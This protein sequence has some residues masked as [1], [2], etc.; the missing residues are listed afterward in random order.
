MPANTAAYVVITPQKHIEVKEAPYTKPAPNQVVIRNRA[1]AVNPVDWMLPIFGAF[2]WLKWPFVLGYDS[3]GEVVEIG[4]SVTR[5]KTGDRVLGLAVGQDEKIN[6]ST[7]SSFQLYTVLLEDLTCSIPD[8]LS[9][10][11]ASVLPLGLATAACGLF[12]KDQL[13]LQLP[14]MAPEPTGKTLLIWGGSTSVGTN[15]I[16]LAVAAGYEVFATCSPRNFELCKSLGAAQC[17]DYSSP[18]VRADIIRAYK[19]K[20]TAGALT[21]GNGAAEAAFDIL[22]H[23][24]GDKFIAM[25]SYPAPANK[26]KHF[27]VPQTIFNFLSWTVATTIKSKSRGIGWKFIFGISLMYNEVG[28]AVFAD[29]L[30]QALEKG[31]YQ[32]KPDPMVV[33]DGLEKLQEAFDIQKKGVSAKKVVLTL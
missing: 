11:A 13:N 18:S 29:F 4:S 21:M 28:K 25:A 32:C 26:P 19:G 14:T 33:G 20:K 12:Q 9:Y 16:Q 10:E 17:F 22:H 7:Q 6:S 3:A 23:C 2:G 1:V 5:F 15:A 24:T 31:A 8:N 30:D 27:V